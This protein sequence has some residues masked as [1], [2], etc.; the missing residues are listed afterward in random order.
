MS[1]SEACRKAWAE[2][3]Q[4]LAEKEHPFGLREVL[5]WTEEKPPFGL[6]LRGIEKGKG[7]P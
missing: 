4:F 3:E 1:T 2:G 5:V 7:E 6:V